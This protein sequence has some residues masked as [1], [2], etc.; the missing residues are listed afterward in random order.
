VI[1]TLVHAGLLISLSSILNP[2]Q[3]KQREKVQLEMQTLKT[4]VA[5]DNFNVHFKTSQPALEH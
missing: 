3:R 2:Y 5:Y 1:E 4:S